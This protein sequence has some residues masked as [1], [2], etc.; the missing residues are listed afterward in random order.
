LGLGF[1]IR[2]FKRSPFWAF[3][4]HVYTC[5]SFSFFSKR[6]SMHSTFLLTA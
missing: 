1:G 4:S 2:S 5:I 3:P 6:W